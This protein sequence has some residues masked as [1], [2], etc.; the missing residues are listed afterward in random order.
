MAQG[1]VSKT[2]ATATTIETKGGRITK[3]N[4]TI[5]ENYVGITRNKDA[6]IAI[7]R[8]YEENTVDHSPHFDFTDTNNDSSNTV[9]VRVSASIED[10]KA[11]VYLTELRDRKRG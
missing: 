5:T 2:S 8:C 3:N 7:L 9:R 11:T 10:K 6:E 4:T 1:V